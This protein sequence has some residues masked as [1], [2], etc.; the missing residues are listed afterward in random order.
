MQ[1]KIQWVNKTHFIASADS[2]HEVPLDGAPEA[3]GQSQGFRPMEL[4]LM[5]LGG[6][7]S[8]D[9]VSIL[10]KSR[11]NVVN[12]VTEITAERATE[13]PHVF[14]SIHITFKVSGKDLNETKVARAVSLYAEKYCSASIMLKR[15]GLKI[16]HDYE[17]IAA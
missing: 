1:A 4:V 16:T 7:T 13:I 2:G 17:I 10:A 15:G 3:G 12:C 14:E 11:Q 5:G 8:F 9:V 6:C